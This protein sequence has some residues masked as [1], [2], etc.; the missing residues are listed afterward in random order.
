MGLR[1]LGLCK[2]WPII[3]KN[4]IGLWPTQFA[5]ARPV[6]SSSQLDYW[7]RRFMSSLTSDQVDKVNRIRKLSGRRSDWLD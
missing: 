5:L 3:G 2:V 7:F 1:A 6:Q 4:G